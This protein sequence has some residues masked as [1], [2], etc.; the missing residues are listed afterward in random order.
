[1]EVRLDPDTQRR[2]DELA[3]A[4]DRQQDEL[5]ALLLKNTLSDLQNWQVDAI[6]QGLEDAGAGQLADIDQVRQ[7]WE[8]R[9]ARQADAKR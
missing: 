8:N 7:R 3:A 2:L 6:R 1:M 4:T 9:R 5:A